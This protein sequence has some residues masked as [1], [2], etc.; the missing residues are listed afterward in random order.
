[1][2]DWDFSN[3][4]VIS[5]SGQG[6]YSVQWFSPGNKT[7]SLYVEESAY[8]S[9]STIKDININEKPEF[10]IIAYPNDTVPS[11]DTIT[12]TG[13][14]SSVSYLW[15]TGETTQSI[16][17]S[18]TCGSGGGCQ[19]YWLE[20]T[21]DSGC[22][23]TEY[24]TV[25]FEGPTSLSDLPNLVEFNVYPNPFHDNLSVEINIL[26]E[27]KFV[28]EVC[29]YLGQSVIKEVRHLQPGRQ[30]IN[31]NMD[32]AG[33]GVHVLSVKSDSGRCQEDH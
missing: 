28:F 12:L 9:D 14:I 30:I 2:Y 33:P 13:D 31:I 20:V 8:Y 6:P 1:L 25:M 17:V 7:V 5:G 32:H 3:A 19:Y 15:S 29:D 23:S 4:N 27:R 24:I 11:L 16:V 21:N 10:S 26:E 18:N 22:I